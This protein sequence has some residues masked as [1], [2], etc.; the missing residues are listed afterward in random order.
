M[1]TSFLRKYVIKWGNRATRWYLLHA[2]WFL[3]AQL[4]QLWRL[5]TP[6]ICYLIHHKHKHKHE[7]GMPNTKQI[8]FLALT[9]TYFLKRR[10]LHWWPKLLKKLL[11]LPSNTNLTRILGFKPE[12][13]D[14]KIFTPTSFIKKSPMYTQK[15]YEVI[16]A[17]T[18]SCM[19]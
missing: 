17:N 19:F 6:S 16:L 2:L 14:N 15:F 3:V 8:S 9:Q 12:E 1:N 11:C 7:Q 5:R 18:R 13:I 10:I 4:M